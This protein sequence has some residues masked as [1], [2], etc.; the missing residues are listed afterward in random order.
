MESVHGHVDNAELIPAPVL[1]AILYEVNL[2]DRVV[3]GQ[4]Q[5]VV[6]QALLMAVWR[7]K[8]R[9]KVLVYS[10]QAGQF[11]SMDWAAYLCAHNLEHSTSCHGNCHDNAVAESFFSL[12]KRERIGRRTCRT[13]EEARRDVFDYI[14]IFYNPKRKHARNGMLSPAK[15]EWRRM[16]R[17]EGVYETRG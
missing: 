15:F 10:D 2:C 6:L 4:R 8:P 1:G 9:E 13:R 5:A 12:L 11:T 14:E 16:M 7:R 17:R 3:E